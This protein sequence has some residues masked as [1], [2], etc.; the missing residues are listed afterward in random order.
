M[1]ATKAPVFPPAC[2]GMAVA[3]PALPRT[4]LRKRNDHF[5]YEQRMNIRTSPR[6]KASPRKRSRAATQR[7]HF[8][9]SVHKPVRNLHRFPFKESK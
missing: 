8:P 4:K 2:S 9:L 3:A 6:D 1:T 7:D 5:P